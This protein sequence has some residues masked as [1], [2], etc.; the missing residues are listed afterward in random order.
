MTHNQ[1]RDQ[2]IRDIIARFEAEETRLRR[3]ADE[4]AKIAARWRRLL[5]CPKAPTGTK[6]E[7]AVTA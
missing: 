4:K 3:E 1:K 2:Q 7:E 6:H 5:A